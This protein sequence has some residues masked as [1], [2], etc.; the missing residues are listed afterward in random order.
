VSLVDRLRG[1]CLLW[2]APVGLLALSAVA[3]GSGGSTTSSAVGSATPSSEAAAAST[4]PS[5]ASPVEGNGNASHA[6]SIDVC[7]LLNL[8]DASAVAKQFKLSGDPSAK[9]KLMT[10]KLPPP[11]TAYPSS[12]CRFTIAQ[13]TA[14]NTGSEAIV[15]VGVQPAKYLDTT[16]TK[17]DG[18]GDEAYDEGPYV[19]VR[20]GDVLLESNENSGASKDFIN[21]LYRAMTPNL[22]SA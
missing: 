17:I 15:T 22:R 5:A 14:D 10:E 4:V 20:V 3:C 7:S 1:G 11:T 12:A 16:G 9:Y 8:A 18:L 19:E 21:A 6:G 2:W 13:V